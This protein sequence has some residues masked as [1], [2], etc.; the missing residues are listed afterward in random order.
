MTDS[1][2]LGQLAGRVQDLGTLRAVAHAAGISPTM[3]DW[4]R[5]FTVAL[6]APCAARPHAPA[7]KGYD[8]RGPALKEGLKLA[9]KTTITLKDAT[10]GMGRGGVEK[11]K[12]AA[13][14]A[15]VGLVPNTATLMDLIKL[16]P[17]GRIPTDGEMR[18][19][20]HGICAA[21]TVRSLS[22]YRA[23]SAAGDGAAAALAAD[24]YLADGIW[25]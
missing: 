25:R 16:D 8:L 18:T 3:A 20:L 1:V 17:T 13:V 9:V 10:I 24:R 15:D 7:P 4:K 12:L 14:F 11:R 5:I 21:G 2:G 6:V 23:A 19:E 22:V